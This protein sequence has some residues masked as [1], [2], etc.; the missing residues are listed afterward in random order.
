MYD[1]Y[2]HRLASHGVV[3]T[4]SRDNL[5]ALLRN[6]NTQPRYASTVDKHLSSAA[7]S[8]LLDGE[9]SQYMVNKGSNHGTKRL[10]AELVIIYAVQ[11]AS[12]L[13]S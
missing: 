4:T 2:D 1:R 5:V 3:L 8:S 9:P 12:S 6:C 13:M 10:L 7:F 11:H